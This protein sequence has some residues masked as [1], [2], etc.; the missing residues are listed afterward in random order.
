MA[1]RIKRTPAQYNFENLEFDIQILSKHFTPLA[2]RD[3]LYVVIH[4]M[5]IIGKGTGSALDACYATWQKRE[6]SANYGVDG[7][8]I[9]QFVW[10]KDYPWACGNAYGN[11]HGMHIEFANKSAAPKWEIASDTLATGARLT[12]YIHKK[13]K[14]GRPTTKGFG[15]GGTVRTHQSFMATACPGPFFKSQW[16]EFVA[17]VQKIYDEIMGVKPP[18]VKPTPIAKT[19][20]VKGGDTLWAIG[21]KYNVTVANLASWNNIKQ[22]YIIHPGQVLSLQKPTSTT[23]KKTVSQL[24]TEVIQGKWGN[25]ADRVKRLKAAGYDANAVQAEVN[26]RLK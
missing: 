2:D 23:P 18:V 17:Q 1:T 22:P 16:D 19:H 15:T 26:R 24:A 11:L 21:R 14:L 3:I 4:H 7:K 10:D 12:A 9:R 13:F 8:L 6:A 5:T 25:G 20:V